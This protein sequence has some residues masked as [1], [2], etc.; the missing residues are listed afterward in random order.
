MISPKP[1]QATNAFCDVLFDTHLHLLDVQRW[2]YGWLEGV[3][4]LRRNW[5]LAEYRTQATASGIGGAL[6]ME[7]FVDAPHEREEVQWA[8]ALCRDEGSGV[9]GLV[10]GVRAERPGEIAALLARRPAGLRGVRRVLHVEADNFSSAPEFRANLRTLEH[11]GLPFELCVQPSQLDRALAL[12]SEFPG[13]TFVLDHGGNPRFD[14]AAF[15]SW[16]QTLRRLAVRPNVWSK[17]S[18]F[19]SGLP[20]TEVSGARL[21]P[22]LETIMTAFGAHRV[23]WGSDWPV[24]TLTSSLGQWVEITREFFAPAS[25]DER[26]AVFHRNAMRLYGITLSHATD[27]SSR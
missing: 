1:T 23:V 17:L 19:V 12:A 26:T 11:S 13:V 14:A 6:F 5:T 18:G 27:T 25:S 10:A 3:P 15:A 21:A 4:S 9:R 16:Q 22:C 7:A 8:A 20:A 2:S 24:C